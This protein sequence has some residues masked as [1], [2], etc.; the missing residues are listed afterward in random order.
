[1][2]PGT[3]DWNTVL[4]DVG[5]LHFSA[6]SPAINNNIAQVCKEA[7]AAAAQKGIVVSLDL[8]YRAKLWK[9]EKEPVEV[10]PEIAAYCD[11]VM[12][13]IW[14]AEE[15][16]GCNMEA[17]VVQK[18]T[19]EAYIDQ[20]LQTSKNII[21]LFPDVK[22]VANTFRFEQPPHAVRYYT[23]LYSDGNVYLSAA[24]LVENII[25]IVGSGDCFMAGLIYGFYN[26]LLPQDTLDFATAA[27]VKKLSVPGDS[28]NSTIA[29]IQNA[30]KRNER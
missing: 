11:V 15:M 3:I 7:A 12:G 10:M 9:Y 18:N 21:Q 8:N 20:A 23:T 17:G 19:K 4:E 13:N 25:D 29:E 16:L 30:I 28:T 26:N 14:A 5:W 6:I 24:Y 2:Q 22:V 27:A 1:L